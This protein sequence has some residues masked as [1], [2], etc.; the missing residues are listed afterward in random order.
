MRIVSRKVPKLQEFENNEPI[1]CNRGF[2]VRMFSSVVQGV[3]STEKEPQ[4]CS[5]DC[6]L[7]FHIEGINSGQ[8]LLIWRGL[9][10]YAKVD[11]FKQ[12]LFTR[13]LALSRYL[14][15]NPIFY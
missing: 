2:T 11:C 10:V 12:C 3:I 5:R 15:E 1:I 4:G 13:C 8:C 14:Q 6:F 9:L 7:L